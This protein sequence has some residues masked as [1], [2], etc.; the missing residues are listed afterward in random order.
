MNPTESPLDML[1]FCISVVASQSGSSGLTPQQLIFRAKALQA[2]IE[3]EFDLMVEAYEAA[4]SKP[5]SK[6]AKKGMI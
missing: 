4:T 5:K 3:K 2:E 1:L 6:K